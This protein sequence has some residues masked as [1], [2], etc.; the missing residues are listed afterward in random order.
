MVGA[1]IVA[2]GGVLAARR[3]YPTEYAG[4]WEFPGGKVDAGEPPEQALVRE[5]AEELGCTVK[6]ESWLPGLSRWRSGADDVELAVALCRLVEGRPA[7][8][9]HDELRWLGPEQ[10]G[11]V[12]WLEPDRPFLAALQERLLDGDPPPGGNVGGAVRLGDTVRRPTGFWTPAVHAALAHLAASA[13]PG[14]PRVRGVD[15]RGREVLDYLPGEVI[16][17]DRNQLTE[18]RL[19]NLGHWLARLH[20]AMSGFSHPG[21]WRFFAVAEPI[22][23]SHNDVA[24]YNVAFVG[25]EVA[26]VFDWD[27]AG[28]TTAAHDLGHTAWSAIPLFRPIPAEEAAHRLR[29]FAGGYGTAAETVLDAV[30]PRVRLAIE[31]IAAGIAAGDPGMLNLSAVGEPER[32]QVALEGFLQRRESIRAELT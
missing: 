9:E 19:S 29:V 16:D 23:I 18:G 12:D 27:F 28:P 22:L 25:D 6:V 26:G 24:P 13:V 30:E 32:T 3:R 7:A 17:V 2:D 4:R 1:A 10:L 31:G 11:D 15:A 8:T 14:V 21:P 20:N 5:I